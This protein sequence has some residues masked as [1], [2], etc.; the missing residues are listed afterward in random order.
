MTGRVP[1]RNGALGF[2][3]IR[4]DVPT[5]VEVLRDQGYYTAVIAKS[6]HMTPAEK[7]PWHAV[8]EQNLG[9]QP[10][11]FASKFREQVAAAAAEQMPFFINANLCDPHRPFIAGARRRAEA[12]PAL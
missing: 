10:T 3:P 4:R 12:R 7:F 9:K 11:Q 1:H 2:D 5:L 8:G 6:A